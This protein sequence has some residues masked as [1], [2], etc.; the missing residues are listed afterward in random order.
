MFN[1][2]ERIAFYMRK[3][4]LYDRPYTSLQMYQIIKNAVYDYIDTCDKAKSFMIDFDNAIIPFE[5]TITRTEEYICRAIC[6]MSNIQ[7]YNNDLNCV[8]G[9]NKDQLI[10][11]E[12]YLIKEIFKVN[13]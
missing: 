10:T 11:C 6:A 2:E 12:N 4:C 7:V 8:N 9:F 13:K 3:E 1:E 5:D